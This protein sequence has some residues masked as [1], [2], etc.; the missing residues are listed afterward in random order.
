MTGILYKGLPRF[1]PGFSGLVINISFDHAV[2]NYSLLAHGC[3]HPNI[4][5]VLRIRIRDPGWENSDPGS[6]I[7]IPYLQHSILLVFRDS[8]TIQGDY[9]LCVRE[10]SKVSHY[11]INKI[12]QGKA[13]LLCYC[14]VSMRGCVVE[15]FDNCIFTQEPGVS[16]VPVFSTYVQLLP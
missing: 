6:G 3:Y 11:I 13:F 1:S 15:K 5:P 4:L 10:D 9:V 12:Q 16:V 2:V 7:N 14:A 8:A